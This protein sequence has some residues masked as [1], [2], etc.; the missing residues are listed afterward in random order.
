VTAPNLSSDRLRLRGWTR[1]DVDFVFDL[2]SREEVQRYIGTAPRVLTDRAEAMA[3]L[4]RWQQLHDP[5]LGVW[6]VEREEDVRPVGVLLLKPIP[7]SSEQRP[8]PLSG[9][10]EIGWHFHPDAWGRGYATEA[11]A[12]VLRH[13]FD[14]GLPEVVAVTNPAN[15]ASQAV[16]ERIG[17]TARGLTDRYYNTTCALF[18]AVNR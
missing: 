5:V 12:R 15:V 7:A 9:D 11:A 17:M 14:S 8:L 3:V 13:A 1:D 6:A 4:D 2:Y 18:T 16:A 10:I